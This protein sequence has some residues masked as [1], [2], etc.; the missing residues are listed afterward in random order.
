MTESNEVTLNISGEFGVTGENAEDV[1]GEEEETEETLGQATGRRALSLLTE[2]LGLF[3]WS[4]L[5]T[6]LLAAV[7]SETPLLL[8]G[9]HGSAK[10]FFLETLASVLN[11]EYRFYN[12]S[13][14]N[15][16]DLVGIPMPSED[17]KRL[18]YIT[19][20]TA[21]WDAEVVFLDEINRTKPELQNK[22]FPIIHE[23]R[24][25]G[26]PLNNLRFRWAAMNPPVPDADYDEVAYLGAEPLD[27]AL[28]DRFGFIIE[29]PSW[30]GLNADE[31]MSVLHDRSRGPHPFPVPIDQVIS[32]C[33][34]R[35]ELLKGQSQAD[36]CTY[37]ILLW[38][39]LAKTGVILSTR[40][41]TMLY[42]NILAAHAAQT[43][44]EEYSGREVRED[45]NLSAWQALRHSLPQRAQGS[46][47]EMLKVSA[48]HLQAWAL[49]DKA[50]GS[51]DFSLLTISDKVER[52]AEALRCR[53]R[54]STEAVTS[55]LIQF[56]SGGAGPEEAHT[57][58]LALYT[59]TH[60]RCSLPTPVL[61]AMANQLEGIFT[62]V[63]LT[64]TVPRKDQ[65]YVSKL[66]KEVP[67]TLGPREFMLRYYDNNLAKRV[68]ELTGDVQTCKRVVTEFRV[69]RKK[70]GH[71]MATKKKEEHHE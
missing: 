63:A 27:T 50:R 30:K 9:S 28:A 14:I 66:L 54:L 17:R 35:L 44:L 58:A 6:V 43:T 26:V 40:R 23:R 61:D 64:V 60:R 70:F 25:Q 13:L 57:R 3:G 46:L 19:T 20:P 33:R 68:Y 22:L 51:E 65:E 29:V 67:A 24:V 41:M 21:I 36:L 59:A 2:P 15:Y 1:S 18:E 34:T 10:S 47:P 55:A 12:A 56:L 48:A 45:W 7:A 38:N 5:E 32:T 52:A 71:A 49:M 42:D 8:V 53:D 39:E 4:E 69:L 37:L 11:L 62:P 31:K 16:D